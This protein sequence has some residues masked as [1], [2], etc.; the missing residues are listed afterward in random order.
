VVGSGYR[1]STH[2]VA[3]YLTPIPELPY[4]PEPLTWRSQAGWL[5][6][7]DQRGGTPMAIPVPMQTVAS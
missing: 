2:T 1:F 7:H 6:R 5:L 3:T 4:A